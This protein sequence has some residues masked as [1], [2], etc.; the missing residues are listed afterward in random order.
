MRGALASLVCGAV[1]MLAATA[2]ANPYSWSASGKS[3]S[4]NDGGVALEC[5]ADGN[6]TSL[7]ANLT[8][9]GTIA[10]T[11]DPMTF[12]DGAT[13]TLASS[14]TVSFAQKVT[15]LGATTLARGDDAYRSWT[16]AAMTTADPSTPAFPDIYTND[17]ISAADVANTWECI[18]VVGGGASDTSGKLS[19]G[20]Y[21]RIAGQI[22]SGSFVTLNRTTVAFTYSI[23]VQLSPKAN[24]TYVRCR[25]GVRSPR[26]GLYPDLEDRWPTADLWDQNSTTLWGAGLVARADRGIWG[27]IYDSGANA[28][29]NDAQV[30]GGTWLGYTSAMGLNTVILKRKSAVGGSMKVRFD[31]GAELGGTTTIPFGME[32]I[33]AVSNGDGAGTFANTITGTGD[34]T[35][36]PRASSATPS[37]YMD[38]FISMSWQ[39]FAANCVLSSMTPTEGYM[40]GGS[41]T[42]Q[43]KCTV[44]GYRYDPTNDTAT[45]QFHWKRGA[46]SAKYV[47]AKFRQNG[48][49]VEIAGVGYGYTEVGTGGAS[50]YPAFGTVEFPQKKV[51]TAA[52]EVKNW[53]ASVATLKEPG[54]E[55][56]ADNCTSGYGIRKITA[57]FNGGSGVATISG[58]IKTL[59]GG[60]FTTAGANGARMITSVTSANGLPAAGEAHVSD[61]T[62]L[63]AAPDTPPGGGTTKVIVHS[64]GDLRNDTRWQLGNPN[65]Q[66]L[67][68][69]GGT[70]FTG[71]GT[72]SESLYLHYV[73]LS[74]ATLKG[75]WSP[76]VAY[77]ST[78]CWWRVIGTEPSTILDGGNYWL[79]VY[80]GNDAAS[81]RSGKC[82]FRIEV[83]DVT[84]DD[85]ADFIV[86]AL[87]G[88]AGRADN[89]YQWFWLEK[90]GPG[91]MKVK[92]NSKDLKME[93][94]LYG[95]TLLL[96]GDNIMTNEVQLLGG[97]IAVDAGKSNSLGALTAE[98]PGTITVGAGGS[99]SFASFA[100]N[101]NL[102]KKSI[103]IDAPMEGNVLRIGGTRLTSAQLSHFRWKDAEDTTKLCRVA[104]DEDGYLHPL[105]HGMALLLR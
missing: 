50:A 25:T 44:V 6:I 77:T 7:T 66:E 69:D 3:L 49:N 18:H 26:R 65:C 104:Q 92:N 1:S 59:Y 52:Y 73:T 88:A 80:G 97:G 70:L 56:V 13:I 76:R 83:A 32:A 45:C 9:G 41:Q 12:A 90:Y 103:I 23:R 36:V 94:K 27:T 68:L 74:N 101:A 93:S 47:A 82:A 72:S 51:K 96:A 22:G 8:D 81:A 85:E 78:Y 15:T 39:V 79:N 102:A 71:S 86:P 61:G 24:G 53:T 17:T 5:D 67:V 63:L 38:G 87:R 100:P 11:G 89:N 55:Y 40:L 28:G 16:G 46:T 21:D 60:K 64:S 29:K 14:G 84:G 54:L 62:L 58:D 35:L 48:P 37:A 57:T 42:D 10:I 19:A 99:L 98:K 2:I 4:P 20:R 43:V 34:F 105:P 31:G 75:T 33:V 91:T 30:Y 95:G